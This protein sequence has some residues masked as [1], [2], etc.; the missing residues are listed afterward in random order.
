M[1]KIF[2]TLVRGAVAEAEEAVFDAN[3]IRVLEQQLRD[4]AG[5][6]ELSR[7]ELACAMAHRASEARAGDALAARIAELELAARQAIDG[8]R[9]DLAEQAATVIAANEDELASRKAAISRFD[10]DIARLRILADTGRQR[11]QELRRGLEMARAQEALHRAGANGRRALRTG[12]GALREAEATLAK[13]RENHAKGDDVAAALDD[14]EAQASGRDLTDQ[15]AK[16]GFGSNTRT[17]PGDVM[18]RLR[19]KSA[20]QAAT[21]QAAPQADQKGP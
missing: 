4:A 8:G 15:L 13:I 18:A 21:P 19:A 20:G 11:L 14:L 12:T 1:L 9:E 3:A 5:A 10:I 6:M 7:R 16:A 17:K 2:T